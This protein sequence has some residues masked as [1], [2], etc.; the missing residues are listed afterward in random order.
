MLSY[1]KPYKK[2]FFADLFFA[3]LNSGLASVGYL[4]ILYIKD[5]ALNLPRDEAFKLVLWSAISIP[6]FFVLLY[7]ST[8]FTVYYGHLIGTQIECD[9]RIEIFSHY[10]QLSMNFHDSRKVGELMSR[11]TTDLNN[12]GE[13]LHHT[14]EDLIVI[15]IRLAF[16]SWVLFKINILACLVTI[17]V[18]FIVIIACFNYLPKIQKLFIKN[19]EK[20]SYINAMAQES[21]SAISSVKV[22]CNENLEIEKFKKTNID[23]FESKKYSYKIFSRFYSFNMSIIF[24][25]VPLVVATSLFLILNQTM[26]IS[27]L[28]TYIVYANFIIGPI[29]ILVSLI[30][31]FEQSL[32]GFSRFIDILNIKPNIEDSEKAIELEKIKGDI[33][34]SDVCFCYPNSK[35]EIL[36]NFNLSIT[37]GEYVALIGPS[38]VGKTT[39]CNLISRLYDATNGSVKIDDIDVRNITKKS[40][41]KNIGFVMQSPYIF[42]DTIRANISYGQPNSSDEEI[43]NAAKK[44][45]AH[46]FI[47][48]FEKKYDT[49]IG[50]KGIKLSGGQKQRIAIARVFLKNPSI[51]I[52]DEATNALD[53]ENE[54]HVQKSVDLLSKNRTTIV[55]AHRLSTI[56]K[57]TRVVVI[58][59]GSVAQNGTHKELLSKK[60]F[61]ASEFCDFV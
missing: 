36:K 35:K 56:K 45:N 57:A 7:V 18:V 5:V 58:L 14:P 9:M 51:F 21:L 59:N 12:I 25:V 50:Q 41:R 37:K 33:S 32:A 2:V 6:I 13:F 39:V 10:Q 43:I 48:R 16:A 46:N 17:S 20:A 31:N 34:F 15:L 49:E 53:P 28:I 38:G 54:K 1:Y 44:A 30:E 27:D 26:K 11:L 8:Q 19:N 3:T 60:G 40:L 23:F 61:Y 47:M 52:F 55:V 29:H 22:F 42:A 4:A 24:I